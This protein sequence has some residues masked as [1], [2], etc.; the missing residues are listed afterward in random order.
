M[1]NSNKLPKNGGYKP[2]LPQGITKIM[3]NLDEKLY[4][5]FIQSADFNKIS[6]F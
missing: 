3:T 4:S 6:N 2:P 1:V 5:E